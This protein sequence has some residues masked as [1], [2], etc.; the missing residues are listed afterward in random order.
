MIKAVVYSVKL[1]LEFAVLSQLVDITTESRSNYGS[2]V[3]NGHLASMPEE[4]SV[5]R[6][7]GKVRDSSYRAEGWNNPRSTSS[8]EA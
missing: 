4:V 8:E 6:M 2:Y 1:K 5:P 7:D 3:K